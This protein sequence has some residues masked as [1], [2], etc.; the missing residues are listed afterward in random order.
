MRLNEGHS[1]AMVDEMVDLLQ[2]NSAAFHARNRAHV[3]AQAAA[4]GIAVASHDARA[5]VR[6]RAAF[7]MP[8]LRVA[9]LGQFLALV[10]HAPCPALQELADECVVRLDEDRVAEDA[11]AQAR[12]VAGLGERARASVARF[13]YPYVLDDWR[14]RM[15]L[16]NSG[17]PDE[18]LAAAEAFFA[19]VLGTRVIDSVGVFVE[20]EAGGE[21]C[22]VE[23]VGFAGDGVLNRPPPRP[24]PQ[25]GGGRVFAPA[26]VV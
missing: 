4:Q 25:G 21:F 16:S 24:F 9:R 6:A 3:L 19:G 15:T 23:R 5:V 26:C 8:A 12:R 10:L 14:F 1:A 22:L 11:A 18:M 20:W 13:G 7:V 17:A 2:A